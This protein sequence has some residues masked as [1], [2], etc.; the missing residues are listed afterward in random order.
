MIAP[1]SIHPSG[2]RY[3]WSREPRGPLPVIP[4]ALLRAGKGAGRGDQ[5]TQP[6]R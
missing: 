5:E 2:K 1:P 4:R 6:G 3:A